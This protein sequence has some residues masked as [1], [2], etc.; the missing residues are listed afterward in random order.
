RWA[1]TFPEAGRYQYSSH[2]VF[3]KADKLLPDS[4]PMTVRVP[5]LSASLHKGVLIM[6]VAPEEQ[7]SRFVSDLIDIAAIYRLLASKDL[8]PVC[9]I[10]RIQ[11][12]I[13]VLFPELFFFIFLQ[14]AEHT[15]V[16]HVMSVDNRIIVRE[17][18]PVQPLQKDAPSDM[19]LPVQ[20][21]SQ[22]F[23]V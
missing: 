21:S 6:N 16:I 14:A 22:I 9:H 19:F 11:G 15:P 5:Y 1:L 18:R 3:G 20:V 8:I 17:I 12:K 4:P 23:F 2:L 10:F 13:L 7:I